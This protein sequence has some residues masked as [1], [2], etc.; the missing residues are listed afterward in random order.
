MVNDIITWLIPNT[1][2]L[3]DTLSSQ[4]VEK[5]VWVRIGSTLRRFH[6][7]HVYHH[8][9]NAHNILL[10]KQ[11]KVWLIDFDQGSIKSS[12]NRWP[13]KNLQ[14]LKRSL[15]KEQKRQT[16]FYWTEEHWNFLMQ[17]YENSAPTSP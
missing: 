2:S 8:D 5:V 3:V 14:R 9:L 1:K 4:P 6:E 12:T 16:I 10:D 17:G 13:M 11:N 15:M 7:K